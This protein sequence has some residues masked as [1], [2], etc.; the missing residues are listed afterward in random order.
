[1]A[2]TADSIAQGICALAGMDDAERDRRGLLGR[3]YA[4]SHVDF[5]TL[6]RGLARLLDDVTA[7]RRSSK[8]APPPTATSAISVAEAR[9]IPGP[10]HV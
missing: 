10:L 8:D 9:D 3:E 5:K 1:M 4:E 6:G 7:S 2:P